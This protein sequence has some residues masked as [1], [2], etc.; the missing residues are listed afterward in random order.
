VDH[1]VNA[2]KE[3]KTM[4]GLCVPYLNVEQVQG[5]V[6]HRRTES[7]EFNVEMPDGIF[8][9]PEDVKALLEEEPSDES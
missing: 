5:T 6:T 4:N 7:I 8:D 2:V 1:V 9:L 3:Y